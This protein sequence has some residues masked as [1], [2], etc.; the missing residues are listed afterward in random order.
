MSNLVLAE[1]W[2]LKVPV[3][4][5]AGTWKVGGDK[6]LIMKKKLVS[7]DY[8][9]SRLKA[10]EM[11]DKNGDVIQGVRSNNELYILHED[12]TE[13]LMEQRE[14]NIKAQAEAAR[15]KNI[16]MSDLVD[17]ISKQAPTT[18]SVE[19][20]TENKDERTDIPSDSPNPYEDKSVDELKAICDEKGLTYHP[21]SGVKKLIEIITKS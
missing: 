18:N 4:I 2:E 20:T 17:A 7:R 1:R 11:K 19:K 3:G 21:R 10:G 6:K 9:K 14:K 15:K 12:E 16:G 8:V 5:K 13:K